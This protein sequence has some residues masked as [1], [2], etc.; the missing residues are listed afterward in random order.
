MSPLSPNAESW[1]ELLQRAPTAVVVADEHLRCLF[2]SDAAERLTGR[3][4]GSLVGSSLTDVLRDGGGM[5]LIE[6]LDRVDTDGSWFDVTCMTGNGTRTLRAMVQPGP[7]DLR[8]VFTFYDHDPGGASATLDHKLALEQLV[9]RVQRR[10]VDAQPEQIP[11]TIAWCLAEVGMHLGADRSYIL[12]FDHAARCDTMVHEWTAP[13]TEP[14]LGTY[15][16]VPWDLT[17]AAT[18]R[19][20]AHWVSAVKDVSALGDD[21][22]VDRAF[23]E[24]SGLLS[25]LELPLVIDG[26]AVG[27]LG[28]DWMTRLAEWTEDDLTLLGLVS[29]S[30]AQLIARGSVEERLAHRA[31][32]DEL[33]G[34]ANRDGLLR[35]L[36]LDLAEL[37]DETQG[38]VAVVMV[39]ID[40]FKVVNDSLGNVAGDALLR[41]VGERLAASVRPTDTVARLGGDA[42]AV[43]LAQGP[44]EPD[45]EAVC[46][47]LRDT[48]AEPFRFL[49]RSH[50]LTVSC[51]IAGT[52]DPDLDPQELVRRAGAAMF[53]SKEDGRSRQTTFDE[54]LEEEL[55]RRL[56]LDQQLRSALDRGEFE[57]HYQPE[58]D[59]V[60]GQVLGAEALLRWRRGGELVPAAVFI[61]TIE[62]TGLIEQ[63]GRWVLQTACRQAVRWCEALPDSPFV[64]RVNLAARQLDRPDLV[65]QVAEAL[66]S[67]GLAPERLCLEV[68]ET[69][70]MNQ[71]DLAAASLNRL[72]ALGVELAI[73]DFGTGYS[74]LSYLKMFPLDVLK[75]DRCFV[76]GLPGDV[77]DTAIVRT[78]IDLARALGMVVTAEG[79]EVAAQADALRALGCRRAQGYL[80]ARPVPAEEVTRMLAE[81][82]L[83][84]ACSAPA[85]AS[86]R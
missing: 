50:L 81:G 12:S 34:L 58:F 71:P 26:E 15:N 55:A 80:F 57:V 48:M 82:P 47:R 39:D 29:A 32:H 25:I 13:G 61:E 63:V 84:E 10:L 21:W 11:E 30:I 42:F 74:S 52:N 65:D 69:A 56:E 73:D 44:D 35:A 7:G 41:S 3:T 8:H 17:P 46:E 62:A 54:A 68:T 59:L 51:G 24:E 40:Q 4:R 77:H 33:T 9:E 72:D 5:S 49:G 70:L 36:S 60:S 37:R 86:R 64:I 20:N 6:R 16:G 28:F 19:N 45:A 31:V 38:R 76:T 23:F 27:G 75:I 66:R 1:R 78:V 67:S 53:R 79:V 18:Q 85:G 2:V 14:E 43:L 83:S 22:A